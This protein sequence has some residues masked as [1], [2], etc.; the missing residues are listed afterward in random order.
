MLDDQTL[1]QAAEAAGMAMLQPYD[2]QPGEPHEFSAGFTKKMAKLV[3]RAKH[4]ALYRVLRAAAVIVLVIGVLFGTLMVASP[5]ARAK[6]FGWIHEMAGI[7]H[8]YAPGETTPGEIGA[9][10]Y[11]PAVPEGYTLLEERET[12]NGKVFV[13]A[14]SPSYLTFAYIKASEGSEAFYDPQGAQPEDVTVGDS[15]GTVFLTDNENINN[16]II[17]FSS[18][19]SVYF[20]ISAK[21]EKD[22]LIALAESVKSE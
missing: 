17:W 21:L 6:V 20:S 14:G 19:G 2:A 15:A 8:H 5:T 16:Q 3:R 12:R 10:Y 1:R 18:D 9:D 4:P 13:Y 7:Y 11:L 22:E